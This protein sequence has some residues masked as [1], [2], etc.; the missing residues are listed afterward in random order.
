M[1]SRSLVV[2]KT[3]LVPVVTEM[4]VCHSTTLLPS[5][6]IRRAYANASSSDC[7]ECRTV[8][9]TVMD[10]EDAS[11]AASGCTALDSCLLEI[12]PGKLEPVPLTLVRN[13]L[14]RDCEAFTKLLCAP[15]NANKVHPP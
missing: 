12:T 14:S 9:D 5:Q 2:D 3:P 11:A 8:L 10:G 4:G 6:R 15:I 1:K 13:Y 7:D